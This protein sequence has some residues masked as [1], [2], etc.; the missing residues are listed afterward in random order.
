MSVQIHDRPQSTVSNQLLDRWKRVP[1]AVIVDLDTGIRQ[2]DPK[3]RSLLPAIDHPT[4]LGRAFTAQ[5]EPPDFGAVMHSLDQI[6]SGDML[7]ISA[8]GHADHAMIGD[9]LGGYLRDKGI[10]GVVCDGA[11]R[12]VATLT[13]MSGFPVYCRHI[14][15]RGP[16]GKQHGQVNN[17]VTIANTRVNSGDWILGDADGLAVLSD[18][19][20]QQWIDAAEAR[21]VDEERWMK[22][23]GDGKA[24]ADVFD[25]P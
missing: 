23:L 25:L 20:L 9:V 21:L 13:A 6:A 5:C 10:A 1:V 4:I 8:D 2:I 19:E 17:N 24:A 14:T 11:V 12:D 22:Q 16:T 15:A 7:V 3:I 18:E